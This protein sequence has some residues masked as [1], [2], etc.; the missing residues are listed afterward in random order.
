[1]EYLH[2][3]IPG[4]RTDVQSDAQGD[5]WHRRH[6]HRWFHNRIRA[7]AAEERKNYEAD[8]SFHDGSPESVSEKYTACMQIFSL[9]RRR[10]SIKM[11]HS[12]EQGIPGT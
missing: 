10:K 12:E 6:L 8:R 9:T 7:A 3:E 2:R 4:L 5:L 11:S 1:M